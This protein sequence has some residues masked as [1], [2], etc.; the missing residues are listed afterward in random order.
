MKLSVIIPVFNEEKTILE[1]LK[2]VKKADIQKIEKEIIIIDDGS[3]D[4]TRDILR[5]IKS[6]KTKDK[7]IKII[8]QD[9]NYGKGFAIRTGIKHS[10]GEII[11][12]Q[13]ADLE[14]NPDEYYKLIKPILEKKAEVVYG[15]RILNKNNKIS[16]LGFYLGGKFLTFLTN[17]LYNTKITDEP[18]CYKI[19]KKNILKSIDLKCKRF[20]FCP[21]ITA[22][23][24]KNKIKILEVPISYNPRHK[25]QGKKI[26][27]RD[28]IIEIWTLFKYRFVE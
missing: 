1:L 15:S 4:K 11:I 9:K 5:K 12:I 24:A 16:S 3:T 23:I 14:Y 18:T 28:G 19:F 2:K 17:L 6:N 7:N 21:E 20:E 22:K 8:F 27:V 13:D 25:N 26:K 10:T